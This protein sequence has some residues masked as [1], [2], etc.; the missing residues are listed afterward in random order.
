MAGV[1]RKRLTD[2]AVAP[3][4]AD[5][6]KASAGRDT[7]IWDTSLAGFGLKI[8]PGGGRSFVFQ[9]RDGTG[10]TRRLTLGSVKKISAS[11][12]RDAAE[13]ANSSARAGRDPQTEKVAA[14]RQQNLSA[15]AREWLELLRL[16]AK[17]GE[18]AA[19]TI[20][21][22]TRKMNNHILPAFGSL[23]PGELTAS[24]IRQWR[25]KTP[26]KIPRRVGDRHLGSEGMKAV[27]RVLSAFCGHLSD[28]EV[29][30]SNPARGMRQFST[31][32]RE[33]H[34]S[35]EEVG[36]L[37]TVLDDWQ[38]RAPHW[39][40]AIELSLQTGMRKGEVLSLRWN[41]VKDETGC[42]V[43]REHKT[44][45][46]SGEKR[47]PLT[48]PVRLV[49]LRCAEWR[50]PE[51]EF[52]FPSVAHRNVALVNGRKAPLLTEL[53]GPMT[54]G[55]LQ[56]AWRAIRKAAGLDGVDAV[57]LHDLRH[58]FAS[59][60][61]SS[62]VSLPLIGRNLGHASAATTSRYA[63]VADQA[64]AEVQ[65]LVAGKLREQLAQRKPTE[66]IVSFEKARRAGG[67][68]D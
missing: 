27:L 26:A 7:F 33:R 48:K 9:Y 62:G 1:Q 34:L 32:R 66:K 51:S 22:Y 20:A 4:V 14:R 39:V 59:V 17:K 46:K 68:R 28:H 40:A 49:L 13:K 50:R 19:S 42:I 60:A 25:D 18:M 2:Q 10:R 24:R 52:V 29:I 38:H 15:H 65:A 6:A 41:A 30:S 45:R 16:R 35:P 53:Q 44:A 67:K 54:A 57:R 43:L 47:I 56:R 21:D 63:H 55:G 31:T 12:A 64:A 37:G 3:L 58:T 11:A 36:R 23:K 5:P 8:S 61:A